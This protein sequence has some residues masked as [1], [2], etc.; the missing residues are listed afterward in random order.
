MP[1][2]QPSYPTQ[3]L[4]TYPQPPAYPQPPQ[5]QQP[6]AYPQRPQY[7]QPPYDPPR[8]WGSPPPPRRS[9]KALI[10]A[11]ALVG[12]VVV[13]GAAAGLVLAGGGKKHDSQP[14][15][16]GAVTTHD[17][18]TEATS[19]PSP[20]PVSASTE[21]PTV[22]A[23]GTSADQAAVAQNAETVL[24]AIGNGDTATFCPLTDPADLKKLLKEKALAG[25]NHIALKSSADTALY[26]AFQVKAPQNIEISGDTA[27]IP[28]SA[29]SPSTFGAVDMRRDSDGAWKFRFYSG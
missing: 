17:F 20:L 1:R 9:N 7:Q 10:V 29:I 12:V 3:Q 5:Y 6:P 27:H 21:A 23:G 28:G 14:T 18:P 4:T 2:Y 8:Q 25:C 22:A 11:L 26:Q 24:H 13:G 16:T 15:P 19:G